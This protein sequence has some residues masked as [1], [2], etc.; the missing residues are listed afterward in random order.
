MEVEVEVIC[1]GGSEDMEYS[2]DGII[3][4]NGILSAGVTIYGWT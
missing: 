4:G 3:C 1:R 2:Y